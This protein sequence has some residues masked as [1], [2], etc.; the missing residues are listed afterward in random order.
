VSCDPYLVPAKA[1]S[2][3]CREMSTSGP[4]HRN[5][6]HMQAGLSHALGIFCD[7]RIFDAPIL[8]ATAIRKAEAVTKFPAQSSIVIERIDSSPAKKTHECL[9]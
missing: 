5:T 8:A 7:R 3:T 1:I 6:T 4:L 9:N 2:P